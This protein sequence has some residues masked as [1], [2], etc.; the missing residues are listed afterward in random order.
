M[1]T[2][3]GAGVVTSGVVTT[4][5]VTAGVVTAG[6]GVETPPGVVTAGFVNKFHIFFMLPKKLISDPNNKF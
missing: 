6:F 5:V 1:E 4:G 2:P 3:P